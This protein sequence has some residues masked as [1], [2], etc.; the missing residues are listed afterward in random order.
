MAD[1]HQKA[2]R[3]EYFTIGYNIAEALAS[4]G[5]GYLAGSIA[6]IGF[7]LDSIV[8]SLSGIVLV[9]RLRRHGRVSMEEEEAI[10]RRAL[11]FVALTFIILGLY[12]AFEAMRSLLYQEIAQATLPGIIIAIL[13]LIVMPVLAW[14][15]IQIA[16][17]IQSRALIADAKE[18]I[19]C[20]IL[21]LALLAGLTGRFLFGFWQADP[22]VALFIAFFLLREGYDGWVESNEE[23]T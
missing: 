19:A 22:L 12:V 21:S 6:L 23:G 8:E 20:A 18:T 4:I 7:G 5:F 11:K 16:K 14:R 9:W 1:L 13:S 17:R 2:L 3:L 10:E 15:K